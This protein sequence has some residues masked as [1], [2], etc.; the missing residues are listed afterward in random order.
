[1]RKLN[2]S[3]LLSRQLMQAV[4][5]QTLLCSC[6][7]A[8]EQATTILDTWLTSTIKGVVSLTAVE[9][10]TEDAGKKKQP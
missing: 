5:Q 9:L 2:T 1:M 4:A 3:Q 6:C 8:Y 10:Y 7:L